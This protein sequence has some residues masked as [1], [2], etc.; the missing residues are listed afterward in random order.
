MDIIYL[1]FQKAFDKVPHLRLL[2]KLKAH[3]ID[4]FVSDWIASWLSDRKQRVLLNGVSSTWASVCSGVPQGSVLGPVLFTV[5]INDIDEGIVSNIVKFAD[6]TK[7]FSC[8]ENPGGV[9]FLQEDLS[10]L[11]QWSVDWQMMFNVDKCKVLH[12]GRNNSLCDYY[13]DGK[14]LEAIEEEKDLGV[15]IHKSLKPSR[16]I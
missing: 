7:I 11:F 8:V 15:I 12:V 4:G 14:V 3:G 13:M 1:D 9:K 10:T 2:C 6:D 16:H 5:F